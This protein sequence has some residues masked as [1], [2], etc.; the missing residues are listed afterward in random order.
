VRIPIK[1]DTESLN[2][3]QAASVLMF[4]VSNKITSK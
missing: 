4:H 2:V 1:H 3:A